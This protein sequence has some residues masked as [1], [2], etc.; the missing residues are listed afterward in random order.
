[1]KILRRL[2]LILL[3]VVAVAVI[4]ALLYVRGLSHKGL[5]DYNAGI[6]LEGMSSPVTVFRDAHGIP[7]IYAEN[8]ADLYRA[9]GYVMAQDRLWQM[10][11]FRRVTMGRL[12]EIFG[13]D[14]IETDLLMR[15]L[16]IPEKSKT[17]LGSLDAVILASLEDF[18]D[19]VNQ[20][21]DQNANDLP[22]EFSLL[23]YK[24]EHWHPLHSLNLIGYMAWDLTAPWSAETVLFKI[25]QRLGSENPRLKD[26]IPDSSLHDT[27]AYPEF[28]YQGAELELGPSLL[29]GGRRLSAMGLTPFSGSNNWAVSGKKSVSGK[30]LFANDMHLGLNVPGIWYQMHQ[31]IEGQLNV[32]GVC[33]AGAPAVVA[34]HN[35]R[36]AWGMTNAMV[37]DMDF[38]VETIHP[39]D[40]DL[41]K[42]MGQWRKMDVRTEK[43]A[44]KGGT[45]EERTLR[46]THR[47]PIVS[48]FKGIEGHALS[49]RW[50]GNEFSNEVR[51][52]HLLNRAGNWEEFKDAV[53]SFFA[54]SQNMIYADVEGNIGL[55]YSAGVPIRKG[56]GISVNPG[57]TDEY[58]WQGFVPFE[59]LPHVY[60]PES[61]YV[62]SANNRPVGDDYPY[63]LSHWFFLPYRIDRIQ[64]MLTAKEKLGVEDFKSMHADLLSMLVKDFLGPILAEL[65]DLEGMSEEEMLALGALMS[66]EGALPKESSAALVFEKMRFYLIRNLAKDELGE[67]LF[68]EFLDCSKLH[69]NLLARLFST[70]DSP[71]CDDGSTPD[72]QEDFTY[73]VQKSFRETVQSL[74]EEFGRDPE[75]WEW[76]SLHHLY[77]QHPLGGVKLLDRIFRLNRGPYPAGGS[78]HTVCPFSYN[79]KNFRSDYGASHRHIFTLEDWDRSWTVIPTGVSGVPSSPYYCDQTALY[80]EGRYHPDFIS[81]PLIEKSALYKMTISAPTYATERK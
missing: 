62:S 49:M 25:A 9:T 66:W 43:I 6:T 4:A 28:K 20:Y 73:I 74:C 46:F 21:I 36:I 45:V 59:E 33:L 7:H 39:D 10:D 18:A 78:F 44:I 26:L 47:G 75:A 68:D 70:Q 48:G 79:F 53:R 71:W 55:Y 12:S 80:L 65:R 64:E 42:F 72:I 37:D 76:G 63:H 38:Y 11:L 31:V 24:P 34:G 58:D 14:L 35:L 40:P 60:N 2:A 3:V 30:P 15:A 27:W 61:G 51:A 32:T 29:S 69:E 50:I 16:R 13:P 17:V 77:L 52:V 57:D 23:R 5:P 22:L 81:R 56:E 1:M 67:E 54:I 8:E 19:G 41:Y